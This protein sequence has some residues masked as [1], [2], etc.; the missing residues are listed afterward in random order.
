MTKLGFRSVTLSLLTIA[1]QVALFSSAEVVISA[2]GSGLANI[3]FCNPGTTEIEIRPTSKR[4]R[5]TYEIIA[6]TVGIRFYTLFVDGMPS[7][8]KRVFFIDIE[9][10]LG[11]MKNAGIKLHA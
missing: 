8:N 9:E 6:K 3:V 11:V 7:L 10:I 4:N 5:D 2:H 1:E